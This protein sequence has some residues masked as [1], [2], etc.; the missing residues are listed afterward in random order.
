MKIKYFISASILLLSISCASFADKILE[1]EEVLQLFRNLTSQPRETWIPAGT[2]RAKHEEYRAPKTTDSNQINRQINED[3]VKC[4]NNPNRQRTTEELQKMELDA[5]PFNTR[6]KL[7][8]E[9]TMNSS[10]IVKS[11][12]EKFYWEINTASRIDSVK[13]DKN[14]ADNF[15]TK[16]F[17]LNWNAR[18]IF[19]WDGEK[20]IT[21]FLSGN[22]AIIDSTDKT[23]HVVNGPLTAGI[24]PWGYGY[25]SYDNLSAAESSAIEK[26]T[27]GQTQIHLTIK[28][29]EGSEML[30]VL[31]PVKNYAVLSC[32]VSKNSSLIISKQYSDYRLIANNWVPYSILLENYEPG[33]TRLL[34]RDLWEITGI[35]ANV[36]QGYEFNV[37]YEADALIEHKISD[38][39]K[40]ETYRYS[41]T[42]NTDLLL[43]ERLEYTTNEGAQKQNCATA[44]VKY[45]A[46]QLGKN[47]ADQQLTQ[48]VNEPNGQT[49]L[50]SMKQSLQGSGLFCRAVKTDIKTLS[51]LN[52]CKAILYIPGKKH[53]VVL[54]KI[55]GN[56]VWIIDLSSNKFYYHTDI[57]FFDMDWAGGTALLISSSPIANKFIE[58]NDS[59]LQTITGLGYS[60]TKLIQDYWVVYCNYIFGGCDGWYEEHYT[61]YGC[62]SGSGSCPT[63]TKVRY[64]ETPCVVD[65]YFP[66]ECTVTGEWTGHYMRACL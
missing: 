30:F 38:V 57:N 28:Y 29:S 6:Y 5:T 17:D 53:F 43:A 10:V 42:T 22:H 11:D 54:E 3:I 24:I 40:P 12:G 36:P 64:A 31:D 18:R 35:D 34:S 8:N 63:S 51:S 26:Y 4:Q 14:L 20:Y 23:P 13:P 39:R 41:Q 37:N 50:Y 47:I 59:D 55:D 21:Y 2:I 52:N 56:Y 9:Y 65:P 48:L 27:D 7:S 15:M 49:N 19:A 25:Y 61:R 66:I 44:A 46:S 1:K 16:Q 62:E 58:I 45:A 60:C 33:T 32:L